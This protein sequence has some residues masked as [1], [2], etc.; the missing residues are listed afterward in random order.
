[1]PASTQKPAP[2]SHK[3]P[4]IV[5]GH[6]GACG[7][8]PEHT[9]T[10]YF[11]AMQDGVDYVE[12]DLVMT[13]DGVLIARHE[14]EIG[15]TTDVARHPEFAGR[16]TTKTIDGFAHTGWFTEDFTL[17]ELKTLRARERIP[18]IRPNNTRFDGQF[19]VPTFEEILALVAG[20]QQQREMKAKQLG[21]PAPSRIGVYPETKHP[22][23]FQGLGLAMEELLVET[24]HRHGYKGREGLAIIQCFEVAN[25]KAMRRMTEL[26]I[27]QL[28]EAEGGPYDFVAQ[29]VKRTYQDMITPEGLAEVATYATG[30]GPY[31]LQVIPRNADD[32]LGAPTSLIKDAH[33]AGLKVHAYTFRAENQF[34]PKNLRSGAEPHR[35]GDLESELKVYLNAGLDGFFTDHADFGARSRDAFV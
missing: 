21:L 10:S 34:L 2:L 27:I 14:N 28:M 17:A 26:P 9:L 4:P 31:K 32:T 5:I 20:V 33:A 18:D 15:G 1:M 12:P 3:T 35:L 6:R 23:Y 11:V 22:T 30:I 16:R 24:L 25:L 8:V 29:G 7:Y 13:K 19:E